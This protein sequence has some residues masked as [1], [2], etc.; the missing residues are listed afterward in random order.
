MKLE[1]FLYPT[2]KVREI[3]LYGITHL[4]HELQH[5][6]IYKSLIDD[7]LNRKYYFVNLFINKWRIKF[8]RY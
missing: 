4:Y 5:Q 3:K 8:L 2:K 7:N 6:L 1:K